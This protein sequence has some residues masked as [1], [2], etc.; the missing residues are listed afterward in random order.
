MDLNGTVLQAVQLAITR[1]YG[2]RTV[3]TAKTDTN[4]DITAR[5]TIH[6]RK[7]VCLLKP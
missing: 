2:E 4:T 7:L 5:R 3:D 6:T 1:V